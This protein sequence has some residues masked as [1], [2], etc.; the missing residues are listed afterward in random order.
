MSTASCPVQAE[1]TDAR[2]RRIVAES[3]TSSCTTVA[4]W[5]NSTATAASIVRSLHPPTAW[6]LSRASTGRSR[7][8]RRVAMYRDIS[9]TR[10]TLAWSA[11]SSRCS[12]RESSAA[13]GRINGSMLPQ[14]RRVAGATGP[15]PLSDGNARSNKERQ[16]G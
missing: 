1:L 2:P 9:W 8:P 10:A 7:L 13:I 5:I 14:R 12:K 16:T 4:P 11:V 6:P 15:G 3:T